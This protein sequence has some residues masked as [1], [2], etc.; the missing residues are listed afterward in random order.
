MD[1]SPDSVVRNIDENN[2]SIPISNS[3]N[4]ISTSK[5]ENVV[6]DIRNNI[7]AIE[8]R[9]EFRKRENS[10]TIINNMLRARSKNYV[11]GNSL[12]NTPDSFSSYKPSPPIDHKPYEM[13]R[14]GFP[15]MWTEDTVQHIIDFGDICSD[16][17]YKC[18][19]SSL[20]HKRLA[21]S[22]QI[23]TILLG[24]LSVATAIMTR[25]YSAQIIINTISGGL[26]A[27][28]TSIQ[29]FFKLFQRYETEANACLELERMSRNI[30]AELAKAKEL[31]VDPYK[32]IIK[33]ENSREEILNKVGIED[34]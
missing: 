3:E 10:K 8:D 26:I 13:G 19:K 6:V 30:K 28:L 33:L 23:L 9:K 16:S 34:D 1:I 27:I 12:S 18:K 29:S 22:M 4:R 2:N 5:R 15:Q 17:A 25:E 11:I 14:V 20:R 31:R 24:A 21:E 32:Y 7:P